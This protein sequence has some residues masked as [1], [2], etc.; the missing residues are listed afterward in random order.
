MNDRPGGEEPDAPRTGERRARPGRMVGIAENVAAAVRR[1]QR[2]REPRIAL[3]GEG[4][5]V[6]L[7]A[8]S[9]PGYDELLE[10]ADGMLELAGVPVRP[11]RPRSGGRQE[12][13]PA[14]DLDEAH[15][16]G[17][18]DDEHGPAA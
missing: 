4:G 16:A 13:E 8:P 7:V 14:A 6:R 11:P 18:D 2:E 12:A 9:A 3:H 10:A 17:A 1:R 5:A 15:E